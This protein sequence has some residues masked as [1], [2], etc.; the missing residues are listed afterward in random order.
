MSD[1]IAMRVKRRKTEERSI[2]TRK[3]FI[4]RLVSHDKRPP[5]ERFV[6]RGMKEKFEPVIK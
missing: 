5:R 3:A 6:D 1:S 2:D 4:A